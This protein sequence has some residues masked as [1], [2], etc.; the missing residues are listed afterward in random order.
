[1]VS[2]QGKSLF[3]IA[4]VPKEEIELVLRVARKMKEVV[5]SD[6]KKL[7]LLQGKS[8]VN[9]F[10]EPS[11]RTRGSFEMAANISCRCHQLHGHKQ[12]YPERGKLQ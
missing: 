6:N 8:I 2:I 9:M 7:H 11:T 12:L 4:G 10:W 1:M 5:N 3:G